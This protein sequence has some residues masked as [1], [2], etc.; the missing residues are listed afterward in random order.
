MTAIVVAGLGG[1]LAH[2]VTVRVAVPDGC[3]T[4]LPRQLQLTV[5]WF[6]YD[7]APG[8][9]S[10]VATPAASTPS[11]YA[12]FRFSSTAIAQVPPVRREL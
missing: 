11:V 3:A 12:D 9:A 6:E 7:A 5:Q 1:G 4:L 10:F 2:N 8:V